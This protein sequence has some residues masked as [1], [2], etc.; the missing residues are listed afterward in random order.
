MG[1]RFVDI[2][3]KKK[4]VFKK[5]DIEVYIFNGKDEQT[6]QQMFKDQI[7]PTKTII[8]DQNAPNN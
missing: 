8:I 5:G 2:W 4:V 7:D 6:M 3:D 1:V